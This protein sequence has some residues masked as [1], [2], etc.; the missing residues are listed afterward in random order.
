MVEGEIERFYFLSKALA[1]LNV[2]DWPR[3]LARGMK[4]MASGGLVYREL[5]GETRIRNGV[6]RADNWV[7]ESAPLRMVID[8]EVDL[9]TQT[10]D[11]LLRLSPLQTI[12]KIVS[13]VPLV[14]YLL[15]GRDRILTALAY[16][17]TGP[18]S[19]PQVAGLS[20]EEED[21]GVEGFFQRL[22]EMQWKDLLPWR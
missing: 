3:Q 7:L 5:E 18:W 16:H 9:G 6:A 12:D 22:K 15:T 21:R 20:D 11:L 4:D 17:V 2:L 13:S 19:D 10:Y 14:G 8:G 1:T